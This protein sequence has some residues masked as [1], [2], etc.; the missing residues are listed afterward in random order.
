MLPA[1]EVFLSTA[2][3]S[4]FRTLNAIVAM[5]LGNRQWSIV[6]F[7]FSDYQNLGD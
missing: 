1:V 6:F 2:C 7:V 5:I 4:W 3:R